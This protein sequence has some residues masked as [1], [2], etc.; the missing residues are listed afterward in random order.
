MVS[1]EAFR[2]M[3]GFGPG[4]PFRFVGF[5]GGTTRLEDAAAVADELESAA[6]LTDGVASTAELDGEEA[7]TVGGLLD[8]NLLS[9]SLGS[10]RMTTFDLADAFDAFDALAVDAEFEAVVDDM[11][12]MD[13]QFLF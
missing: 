2:F 1:C 6:L 12:L 10:C 3:P 5:E 7:A 13:Q 9:T 8:G 11:V 4:I